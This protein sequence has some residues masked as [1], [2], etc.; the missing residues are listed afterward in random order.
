MRYKG[1][2]QWNGSLSKPEPIREA[3]Q[4][5]CDGQRHSIDG[6]FTGSHDATIVGHGDGGPGATEQH[7]CKIVTIEQIEGQSRF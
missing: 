7:R 3:D 4:E 1:S 2:R 5:Q 6:A